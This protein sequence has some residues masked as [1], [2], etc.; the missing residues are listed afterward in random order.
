MCTALRCS[1]CT[2]SCSCWLGWCASPPWWATSPALSPTSRPP[3]RISKVQIMNCIQL[4]TKCI[5]FQ[6]SLPFS[7]VRVHWR[8]VE[9]YETDCK[10]LLRRCCASYWSWDQLQL[11]HH[12]V[13][14]MAVKHYVPSDDYFCLESFFFCR[15]ID[16]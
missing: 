10:S 2:W 4:L 5:T 3:G 15:Q 8:T 6:N 1:W 12:F 14:L 13:F 9:D 11:W 16:Q 7:S